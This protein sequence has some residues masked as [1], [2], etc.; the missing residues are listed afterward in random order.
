MAHN[1]EEFPFPEYEHDI[2]N[3][4]NSYRNKFFHDIDLSFLLKWMEDIENIYRAGDGIDITDNVIS[5]DPELSTNIETN[6]KNIETNTENIGTLQTSVGTAENDIDALETRV[7]KIEDDGVGVNY[8]LEEKAI[9]HWVDGSVLYQ[10]TYLITTGIGDT[11]TVNIDKSINKIISVEGY[12]YTPENNYEAI[13]PFIW[14][15]YS[16]VGFRYTPYSGKL[17]MTNDSFGGN[18][19]ECYLT[20]RYIK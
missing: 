11:Y 9:G 3:G 17:V 4:K 5:I 20:L 10:K 16:G 19:I 14:P 1:Y 12:T 18:W 8:S 7:S 2:K 15:G 6:T 13:Y